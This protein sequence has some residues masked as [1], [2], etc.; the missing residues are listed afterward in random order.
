MII[1][2]NYVLKWRRQKKKW[3][4]VNRVAADG[5]VAQKFSRPEMCAYNRL[6]TLFWTIWHF[7]NFVFVSY[8]LIARVLLKIISNTHW[9]EPFFFFSAG[10]RINL[11]YTTTDSRLFIY[12]F[13][14]SLYFGT[15]ELQ[16]TIIISIYEEIYFLLPVK[17]ELKFSVCR[18]TCLKR[19]I[20]ISVRHYEEEHS[21]RVNEEKLLISCSD[22]HAV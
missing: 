9:R 3:R 5:S 7:S 22:S 14:Y 13:F 19:K 2:Q 8:T 18:K 6:E 20:L 21:Y 12:L 17:R 10:F 11:S 4:W 1:D 15:N 16:E